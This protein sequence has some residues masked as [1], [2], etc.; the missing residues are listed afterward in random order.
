[1]KKIELEIYADE[2]IIHNFICLGTLF[3]PIDKKIELLDTL[4]NS[5]CL[6]EKNSE[7][8]WDYSEC[9]F[10]ENC[11]EEWHKLN[12]AEIHWSELRNKG[13]SAAIKKISKSWLKFLIENNKKDKN[14]IYF[15]I[16][17]LDLNKLELKKFGTEKIHENIYNKFFRT[18]LKTGINF[19]FGMFDNIII[20]KVYHDVASVRKHKYFPYLNLWKLESDLLPKV[21]I[22]DYNIIFLDSNH[23]NYLQKGGNFV[24]ESQLIQFIDLIIGSITQNIFCLS[25][26]SLK[27]ELSMIIRPLVKR[28]LKNPYNKNSSYHHYRKQQIQIFPK[29]KIEN[30][31]EKLVSLKG[32]L[33]ENFK[34]DLFYTDIKLK[35]P[36]FNP[37]QK[38][39]F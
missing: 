19:F 33:T 18:V 32:D 16:L 3:L 4:I 6:Y 8:Y 25:E 39:L 10:K 27:K 17:Y 13:S 31:K 21:T 15:N 22:E 20:K 30:A 14:I 35:M 12:S 5:R 29:Y 37:N 24:N 28:L 36:E 9:P 11:R 26:D 2:Q 23:K 1:M 7:W 38:T 34:K